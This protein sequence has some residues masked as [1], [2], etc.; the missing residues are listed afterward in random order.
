MSTFEFIVKKINL[1]SAVYDVLAL[2]ALYFV[3]TISHTL[4]FPLYLAEPMRIALFFAIIFT[5]RTNAIIIAATLPIVSALISSHP[6][7]IK[8]AIMSIELTV[9]AL[10]FYSLFN[11]KINVFIAMFFSV[12]LSKALYYILEF[13]AISLGVFKT[14]FVHPIFI[15]IVIAVSLGILALIFNKLNFLQRND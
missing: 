9:N 15:Q 4:D 8:G 13:A 6:P 5:A 12:V 3:P 10:L 11:K 7:L 2:T 1:K 14:T